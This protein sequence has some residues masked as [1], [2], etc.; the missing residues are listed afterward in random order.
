MSTTWHS[1]LIEQLD[2]YWRE[3]FRPRLEGLSDEEYLWEPVPNCWTVRPVGEGR[4]APDRTSPE[5][6]PA[7]VTTIAWRM[8]HIGGPVLGLRANHEFG[9]RSFTFENVEWPGT[10]S[11]GIAFL[12]RWYQA[13][14]EGVATLDD[15]E[16]MERRSPAPYDHMPFASLVLHINRE[17]F[18]HA[19]EVALLRDLWRARSR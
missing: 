14:V 17:V 13:W 12:E 5:P 16:L 7:P 2:W 10:A 3:L 9:D 18:H 4:F 11:D 1:E 19:A 15:D 8:C 6:T